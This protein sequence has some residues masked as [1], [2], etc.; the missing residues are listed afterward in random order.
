M[1]RIMKLKILH[2]LWTHLPAAA[3]LVVYVVLLIKDA[4]FPSR[5]AVHFGTDGQPNAYGSPWS[6]FGL[7]LGLSIFFILLSI[8]LD[9][10]W[11]RH[12]NHKTFNWLSLLDDIVVGSMTGINLGYLA[13]LRNGDISFKYPWSYF[14][15][16]LG[17]SVVL[18]LI[19]EIF[20]PYR[21]YVEPVS[22]TDTGV[23]K[24]ELAQRIR[25]D[26][27]FVYWDIQN[28]LYITL[29]TTILPLVMLIAAG[30]MLFTLGWAA[31]IPAVV[32]IILVIPYSGQRTLV[33]RQNVTI[34]WGIFGIR[35]FRLKTA[36]ITGVEVHKFSPLQDFGGYGIRFNR[37]MTAYYLSGNRGVKLTTVSG[38]KYLI[39]S[40][41]PQNL[42][43][44]I[45]SVTGTL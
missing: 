23:L 36:D 33:T 34:R 28:P 1:N 22:T 6:A 21:S 43:A 25:N 16:V 35:V 42:E 9:E 40:D 27:S 13:F 29:L 18:A 41:Q 15:L 26:S 11:V 2:P 45:N 5:V 4:P 31:I 39:G 8:L 19:L 30:F 14:S 44:A 12:E 10:I 37:E 24:D 3:A 17:F 7:T 20:R 38:K 32:A